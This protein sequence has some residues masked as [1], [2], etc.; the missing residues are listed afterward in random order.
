MYMQ[1][2]YENMQNKK[3]NGKNKSKNQ[4]I[5]GPKNIVPLFR[6]I[7]ESLNKYML[8]SLLLENRYIS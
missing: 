2:K 7:V 3:W 1:D 5:S 8:F 6:K 4:I